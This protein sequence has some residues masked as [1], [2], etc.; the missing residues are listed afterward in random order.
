MKFGNETF[1]NSKMLIDLL[2]EL[3]YWNFCSNLAARGKRF[4]T[5]NISIE[6]NNLYLKPFHGP[7]HILFY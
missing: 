2:P 6:I 3:C 7:S 1:F 4:T 5:K